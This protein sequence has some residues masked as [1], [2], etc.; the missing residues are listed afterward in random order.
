MYQLFF[1]PIINLLSLAVWQHPQQWLLCHIKG[2][3]G[4]VLVQVKLKH[5]VRVLQQNLADRVNVLASA[6]SASM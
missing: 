4:I 2:T 1:E 5:P 6:L 3:Y